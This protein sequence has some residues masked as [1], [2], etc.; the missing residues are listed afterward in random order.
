MKLV[1]ALRNLA[2]LGYDHAFGGQVH[3]APAPTLAQ[4]V[5]LTSDISRV[6]QKM[7]IMTRIPLRA[8]P[9]QARERSGLDGARIALHS[10]HPTRMA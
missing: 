8:V 1:R 7:Y 4:P 10:F 5:Q 3:A 2:G 9:R 6:K